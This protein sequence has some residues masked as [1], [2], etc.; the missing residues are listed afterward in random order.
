MGDP[1]PF[2]AKFIYSFTEFVGC[3]KIC[4][5]AL[6]II[7]SSTNHVVHLVSYEKLQVYLHIW[8]MFRKAVYQT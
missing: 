2:P 8:L 5:Q 4:L 1:I 7:T 6:N 3:S